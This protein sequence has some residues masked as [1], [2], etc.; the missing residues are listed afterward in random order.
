MLE[1]RSKKPEEEIGGTIKQNRPNGTLQNSLFHWGV[2]NNNKNLNPQIVKN[3]SIFTNCGPQD[4]KGGSKNET[5]IQNLLMPWWRKAGDCGRIPY[6]AGPREESGSCTLMNVASPK[7]EKYCGGYVLTI[8]HDIWG[9]YLTWWKK[10]N[11]FMAAFQEMKIRL[12]YHDGLNINSMF[13]IGIEI[14][15]LW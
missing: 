9:H 2:R 7:S 1:A 6:S 3:N 8:I 5:L 15:L 13:L 14:G 12:D 11:R 10:Y 4:G